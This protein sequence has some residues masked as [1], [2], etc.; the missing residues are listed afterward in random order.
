MGLGY[1]MLGAI[2]I[3]APFAAVMSTVDSLLLLISSCAVRDIYQR[4]I[5]PRVS[6]QLVKRASYAPTVVVGVLVT[7]LATQPPDFLQRIV[8]FVGGGFAAT[9]VVPTF[10]GLYWKGMTRQGALYSMAGGLFIV[11]GL[12]APLKFGKDRVDLLGMEP[13]I[14]GLMG[15]LVLAIVVSKRTG[16]P[17]EHLVT[18][19]FKKANVKYDQNVA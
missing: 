1:Q 9:F 17:P 6:D 15:S 8:V 4:T 19:Y 18:L 2:F 11:L 13:S 12:C 3:A 10:L 7:A 14:W 5:N 16:P